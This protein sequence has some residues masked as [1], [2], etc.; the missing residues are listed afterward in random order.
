ME[1]TYTKEELVALSEATLDIYKKKRNRP[2]IINIILLI[3]IAGTGIA[4]KYMSIR[5][6]SYRILFTVLFWA[7]VIAGCALLIIGAVM[8]YMSNG[9]LSAFKKGYNEYRTGKFSKKRYFEEFLVP[10]WK[11][12]KTDYDE[13]LKSIK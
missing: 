8:F 11:L 3:I 13:I 12:V 1:K 5:Y 6:E 7:V 9:A 4:L 2:L 10:S